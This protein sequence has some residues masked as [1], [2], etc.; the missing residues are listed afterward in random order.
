MS[1]VS[2]FASSDTRWLAIIHEIFRYLYP[3]PCNTQYT[4][5]GTTVVATRHRLHYNTICYLL[6]R[7]DTQ[8]T[9]NVAMLQHLALYYV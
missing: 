4:T 7:T 3:A 1:P 2:D 9:R 6:Y 5:K 8:M